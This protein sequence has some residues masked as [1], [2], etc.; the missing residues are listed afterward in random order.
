MQKQPEIVSDKGTLRNICRIKKEVTEV[1]KKIL[2][3]ALSVAMCTMMCQTAFAAS[4]STSGS[5]SSTESS[6]SSESTES[7]SS[8]SSAVSSRPETPA[9]RGTENTNNVA[10]AIRNADGTVSTMNLT[11]YTEQTNNSV[12]AA[13]AA[14][15]GSA[16]PGE[17]VSAIMTTP[18][19]DLFK[20][21]INALGGNIRMVNA[22][23][24]KVTAAA[25]GADGRTVASVGTV[26]GVT[27]YAFVILISVNEDGTTEIV[28]G[29]VDPVTLQ[30]MG[31]FKGT[32]R[33]ITVSVVMAR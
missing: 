30:V 10:V 20:A 31:A 13:A 21:T 25:P 22:G 9:T 18:A 23:G 5:S 11:Q 28:E 12:V 6:S 4:S 17:A 2:A 32:P 15:I 29:T 26:K 16:N 3:V 19:S 8:S 24:Y 33:T 7:V 27:K 1:K 14:A